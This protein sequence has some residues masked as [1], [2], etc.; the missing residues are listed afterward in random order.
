MSL[1]SKFYSLNPKGGQA[2]L[3]FI[4]VVASII[5]AV[6][7]SFV[8]IVVSLI[9]SAFAF[10]AAEQASLAAHSGV[11]DAL[12][13]LTRNKDFSST[14]YPLT[15][16]P[17]IV[18]VSVLPNTPVAGQISILSKATIG[19][20]SRQ[21]QA[22]VTITPTTSVVNILSWSEVVQNAQSSSGGTVIASNPPGL[23]L[24]VDGAGCT[25]PCSFLWNS[26]DT[27]VI[28]ASSTVAGS[29]G[30]QYIYSN[31]S[32][33]GAMSHSITVPSSSITYTA[34]FA[35]QYFLNTT[36][37]LAVGGS[38][39][40]ISQWYN[41]GS[42]VSVTASSSGGY[43]FT[44]FSG[45]LSGVTT[46]QNVIMSAPQSVTASFAVASTP[47]YAASWNYRQAITIDH[48][49]VASSTGTEGYINFPVLVSLTSSTF[50]Y[51]GSGGHVGN[52]DGSDVLF[53]KSDGTT[54]LDHEIESYASSTGNL[55]AWVQL[56]AVSTS[57]DTVFYMY[58]G[59]AGVGS[60]QN[61][62][63]T[64]DANYKGV[65][66]LPNGTSLTVN[67]STSNA[68]NG[69]INGG[70][71]STIGQVD[72]AGLFD[73]TTGYINAPAVSSSALT[74]FTV[75][76]WVK[77][78]GLQTAGSSV[79]SDLY[80]T[81]VNYALY[82]DPASPPSL[83]FFGG[84][85]TS[86][87]WHQ[88]P[89]TT[90]TDGAWAYVVLTYDG[91]TVKLYINNN[92]SLNTADA[93]V[94]TSNNLGFRIGR[95][96]DSANNVKGIIDEVRISSSA[97]T[98]DW[99][100]TEYNNQSSPGSFESFTGEEVTLAPVTTIASNPSGLAL[101]VDGSACTAPCSHTWTGGTIHTIAVSSTIAGGAGTQYLYTSWSDAGA[102]SHSITAASTPATYTANFTTQYFLTTLA[103]STFGGSISPI[104][105]WYNSG[106]SVPV[107]ASTSNATYQFAGFTGALSGVTT[108]QSVVMSSAQSVT[109]NF[110]HLVS[111]YPGSWGFRQAI[112]INHTKVASSTGTEGYANFPVL[113]SLAS[114]TLKVSSF[115]GHMGNSD[116]SDILF[117]M[118]DGTT[119]LNHEIETY[120][121]ST[122]NVVAW[123]K[124][125]SVST[126][127]DGVFYMYY[128]N[129]GIANQQN[130]TST[131][132]PNYQM[133]LHMQE[134]TNP[135]KDSTSNSYTSDSGTN[136]TRVA[137]LFGSAQSFTGASSQYIGFSQTHSPNP[138]GATT[139]EIWI[140]TTEAA[141]KGIA[142]KWASDGG[143]DA[144]QSFQMYYDASGKLNTSLNA[145][146]GSDISGGPSTA[147]I[148]DGSW[149]HIAVSSP[150]TGNYSIF[151]DGVA[152]V[153]AN[154][155]TLLKTTT[156]RLLVGATSIGAGP[157]Y[158][159][160][161]QQEYRISNTNRSADWI[162]TEYNNQST[163]STFETFGSEEVQ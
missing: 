144:N 101:T 98:A 149:H 29:A 80:S 32:D 20:N 78:N 115:G 75:S 112:T 151:V 23:A 135:Y 62:S 95:R 110:P 86:G 131:W 121:S 82:F 85:Y 118:S 33:S 127:T 87:A 5:I 12:L 155:N 147:A 44:G 117:T 140:K 19:T 50:K 137:G 111:W 47:W 64:W 22:V 74:A 9:N 146:N 76:T 56:P 42:S 25:T 49:K 153:F 63:G 40:P 77:P 145:T 94:P 2:T 88:A 61:A 130:A 159:T 51:T 55:V 157:F 106:T 136:P 139:E 34:N 48:T 142:G 161:I 107:S 37:S 128:G 39:T 71:S 97:R 104:S 4:F 27:H 134:S 113:V 84:Y 31:W 123:V 36:S 141:V 96:W 103:S 133:V 126:T 90:L 72:G 67:D 81:A 119:K 132:D 154:A 91:S 24:N 14:G 30:T 150:T 124:L 73:G 163:P 57:T 15:V 13:I 58:Y 92:A 120:T 7:V 79:V 3:G 54:K 143:A 89:T 138:T 114:T 122:G 21:S 35:I 69:T 152:G 16:G 65:W 38:I 160:S 26:G 156:D 68:K 70:V 8:L 105:Q 129:A 52:S 17:S 99:I 45:A 162:K 109:A 116:G 60:Q 1:Y 125:P 102:L 53:T 59:N 6:S 11:E 148:N 66:H 10:Q 108:P 83:R 158:S 46:P 100:R 93:T 18:T 43:S 41:S 28:S